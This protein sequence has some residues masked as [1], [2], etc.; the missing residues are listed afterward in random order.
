MSDRH[1]PR[2]VALSIVPS[3]DN[4]LRMIRGVLDYAKEHP[5]F[6]IAKESAVP[7][8][9]LDALRHGGFDGVVAYAETASHLELLSTLETPAVN[10][11][12]HE[13]PCPSVPVVHSDNAAIGRLAAEHFLS[14]GLRNFA[15]VGHFGWCHNRL[16]R[17]AFCET[18]REQGF[19][20]S[21]IDIRFVAESVGEVPHR[22]ID[23]SGLPVVFEQLPT[24]IGIAAAHDEF[25]FEI[26]EVC[27]LLKRSVPYEVAVV[28]VNDSGLI[29]ETTDPPL[30]S[31]SQRSETI[32][33][34]AARMVAGL[35]A[36]GPEP[37][38]PL[39]VP[40]SRL[41]VRRSSGFL[42]IDD[43]IVVEAVEYIRANCHRPIRVTDVAEQSPIG[44]R[45]LDK[46]FQKALG[47]PAAEELR[48]ARV[49]LAKDMLA[50]TNLDIL[51]VGF[52]CGFDSKSGFARA[53]RMVT[54]VVPSEYRR[55][56]QSARG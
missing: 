42:A 44:R 32:G 28:G 31:I 38:S 22:Q 56:H 39:L 52:R 33:Y 51:A 23:R 35:M 7:Y 14:L 16:R 34:E 21:S 18:V 40:P 37:E 10:V 41:V 48:L 1:R 25:A 30:S 45:T 5:D 53:F 26:V 54:G 15:F 12:L 24:P 17:D 4:Q 49:R 36:G 8:V 50:T 2:R 27:R 43:Q 6:V 11:T 9:R 29:C 3:S 46:R 19:S 55:E 20:C 13:E 47:H